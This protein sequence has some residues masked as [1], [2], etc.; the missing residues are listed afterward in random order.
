MWRDAPARGAVCGGGVFCHCYG[1]WW[2]VTMKGKVMEY[3]KPGNDG[4]DCM[5]VLVAVLAL[6][7]LAVVGIVLAAGGGL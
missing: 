7:I 3:D 1:G 6:G 2:A 5:R 4:V